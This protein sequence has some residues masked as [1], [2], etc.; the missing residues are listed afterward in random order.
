MLFKEIEDFI[1]KHISLLVAFGIIISILSFLNFRLD[2]PKFY[3]SLDIKMKILF[4]GFLNFQLT[5][6]S[7]THLLKK[8]ESWKY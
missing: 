6:I 3:N 5:I 7:V 8:F 2:I 4:I 1:N